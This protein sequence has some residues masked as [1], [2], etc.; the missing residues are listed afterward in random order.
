MS[1]QTELPFPEESDLRSTPRE[2][3]GTDGR[4]VAYEDG[5]I[6]IDGH[7]ISG[8][9]RPNGYLSQWFPGRGTL[10]LH[11]AI[12]DAFHGEKPGREYEVDHVNRD[13]LDNRPSNLRWMTWEENGERRVHRF[14]ADN[15]G[16]R[17]SADDVRKLRALHYEHGLSCAALSRIWGVHRSTAHRAITGRRYSNVK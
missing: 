7:K 6:E 4:A 15:P 2:I 17:F 11:R 10:Y 14:G 1:Q 3:P 12:C 13:R 5:T 9:V 8:G 16:A